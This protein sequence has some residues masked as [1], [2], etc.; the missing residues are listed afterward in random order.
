[1]ALE[2]RFESGETLDLSP[3]SARE[4]QLVSS[5]RGER[6][7]FDLRRG[8][9]IQLSIPLKTVYQTRARKVVVLARLEINGPEHT[10]P[11]HRK[12]GGNHIH[13]Y[14]EGCGDAWA[15]PLEEKGFSTPPSAVETLREF[16]DF[17][18]ITNLPVVQ[19]GAV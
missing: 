17:C 12:V 5:E 15:F 9:F 11:D 3:G 8:S 1:L 19:T 13:I 18:S 2:K 16:C 7:L 10:N 6:F 4:L 14:R